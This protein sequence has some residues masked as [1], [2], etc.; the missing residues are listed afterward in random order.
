MLNGRFLMPRCVSSIALIVAG[1]MLAEDVGH[2][3][4]KLQLATT[5]NPVTVAVTEYHRDKAPACVLAFEQDMLFY[6]ALAP[7]FFAAGAIVGLCLPFTYAKYGALLPAAYAT[8]FSYLLVRMSAGTDQLSWYSFLDV[9]LAN[10]ALVPIYLVAVNAGRAV[11]ERRRPRW[12]L[13]DCL[14]AM[15]VCCVLLFFV[16][17]RPFLAIPATLLMAFSLLFWRTMPHRPKMTQQTKTET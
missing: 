12:H 11:V 14:L 6:F 8:W 17:T 4:G 13:L 5:R 15:T 3:A 10:V 7:Y 1:V 2:V 9:I 16:V